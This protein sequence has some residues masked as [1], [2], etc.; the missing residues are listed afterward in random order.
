MCKNILSIIVISVAVVSGE[1]S[2]AGHT[3]L[4]PLPQADYTMSYID[5]KT[6]DFTSIST[7]DPFLYSWEVDGVGTFTGE[8]VQVFIGSMGVYDI[9]HTVFNQGGS[10]STTGQVEIYKDGPPPC[11]GAVEWLTECSE[12]T[13][14]LAP[15]AGALW[16]GS[17]MA[18][19][20]GPLMVMGL[21]LDPVRLM[22]S[23]PL[24]QM[25]IWC[26]IQ[27]VIFGRTD[28][29][30]F[31]RGCFPESDLQGPKS[32]WQSGTHGFEII[33]ANATNPDQ[34]KVVGTGAFIGL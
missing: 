31:S 19:N 6:V 21:L 32:A 7:G 27:M 13:W 3:E 4:G 2:E 1:T 26:T 15:Q 24:K 18:N 29:W 28:F 20:G 12:R 25:G 17:T 22:M 10:A 8:N 30:I 9:T 14:K 33:P 11:V 23:G 5:S 34:L 16:V